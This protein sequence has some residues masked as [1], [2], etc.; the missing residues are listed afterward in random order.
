MKRIFRPGRGGWQAAAGPPARDGA[1]RPTEA[2]GAG[3]N[4]LTLMRSG[5]A[6]RY[7]SAM[8]SRVSRVL[9]AVL[10]AVG[11]AGGYQDMLDRICR[12]MVA[13]VPC[14][15]ATIYTYSRHTRRFP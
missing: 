2:R 11:D 14:D 7:S 13:A 6:C 15:R 5:A 4:S 3:V 10:E 9:D 8:D 12:A 1:D